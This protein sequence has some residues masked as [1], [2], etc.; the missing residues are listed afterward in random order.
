MFY[1]IDLI[2]NIWKHTMSVDKM[3]VDKMSVDKMSVDKM[4]VD[5]MSAVDRCL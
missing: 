3:S 1:L 5:K 2:A 4:S